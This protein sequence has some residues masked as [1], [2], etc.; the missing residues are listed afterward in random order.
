V[1]PVDSYM[2]LCLLTRGTAA[3]ANLR[4]MNMWK[5]VIGLLFLL[6]APATLPQTHQHGAATAANTAD[7]SYNPFIAADQHGKFYLVYVQRAGSESNVMLRHSTDGT[8]FSAPVRVNDR[9]GDATMRNENPPKVTFGPQ[10][11][12]Y[13]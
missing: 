1:R 11:E 7:G 2:S 5:I 4:R 8:N 9:A 3:P 12:I 10:G 6:C 13:V